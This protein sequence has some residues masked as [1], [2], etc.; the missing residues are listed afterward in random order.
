MFVLFLLCFPVALYGSKEYSEFFMKFF[1]HLRFILYAE[2]FNNF[3]KLQFVMFLPQKC[4]LASSS[5][6]KINV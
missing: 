5:A 2:T 6:N 3:P 4:Q 1:V